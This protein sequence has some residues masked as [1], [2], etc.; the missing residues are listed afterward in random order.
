[1][2][3]SAY[4]RVL[5]HETLQNVD[6]AYI[7]RRGTQVME[8]PGKDLEK[9]KWRD[10]QKMVG[11]KIGSGTFGFTIKFKGSGEL[12][13][14]QSKAVKFSDS[15]AI[16]T[17]DPSM[18]KTVLEG[19]KELKKQLEQGINSGGITFD[20][21]IGVT[22]QGYESQISFLNQQIIFK[23]G[24][25]AEL[26]EDLRD[27]ENENSSLQSSGG[28]K[29][30]LSV[31]KD[32]ISARLAPTPQVNLQDSTPSE[33]PDDVLQVLGMVDWNR[34]DEETLAGIVDY[35]KK[36]IFKFLPL[37]GS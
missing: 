16:A 28:I 25:I 26:K 22:K 3:K 37:K 5:K 9:V 33:I 4:N 21:L 27:C 8:I 31:A 24:V 15:T 17:E 23:D 13:S 30:Y 34:L 32:L 35:L 14:G 29:E 36:Y 6:Y 11:E 1:M 2:R 12:Y 18:V 7:T 10:F 19:F 20:M